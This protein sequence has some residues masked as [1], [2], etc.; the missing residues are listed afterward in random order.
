MA[1]SYAARLK[2]G[3][4][5]GVCGT[6]ELYDTPEEF[7]SKVEKLCNFLKES[8]Y[9]VVHTGAGISTAC[10]IPDFRGPNGVWTREL[11]AGKRP[12]SQEASLTSSECRF[13]DARPSLT[14][15]ALVLLVKLGL[16]Q[17]VV[18]QNVDGLHLRSGLPSECLAELHGN[19]FSE[20]CEACQRVC[21][22]NFEIGS[23]GLK[24]TGRRCRVCGGVL[25]DTLL[26]WDDPLP[27]D[28]LSLSREHS[29]R[30]ELALV[31]GSSLRVRPANA[32][33]L[34]T[35]GRFVICNLQRTPR[36]RR[37]TFVLR[38]QADRIM[39]V[40]LQRL[41]VPLL[42]I[43]RLCESLILQCS[44]LAPTVS[45]SAMKNSVKVDSS[46]SFGNTLHSCTSMESN[47]Q[48]DRLRWFLSI[49]SGD[50][51]INSLHF[52]SKI[53]L[54]VAE[55]ILAILEKPPFQCEFLLST[56]QFE[57]KALSSGSNGNDFSSQRKTLIELNLT[58]HLSPSCTEQTIAIQFPLD[59]SSLDL[60]SKIF[61]FP[62]VVV[63]HNVSLPVG[64]KQQL[65]EVNNETP[66]CRKR[67]HRNSSSL[68]RRRIL[69]K[70]VN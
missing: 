21:V 20:R 23:I 22:R 52:I 26:D 1:Q 13:E 12:N 66:P 9:T 38:A 35:R 29:R 70:K 65:S 47:V 57:A 48:C 56:S 64:E 40:L 33:P 37:A 27:E 24:P 16:V 34:E 53:V 15:M 5:Y 30:A 43:Y 2:K 28:T 4:Y 11:R 67:R 39:Y 6:P 59:S 60:Q 55:E 62:V 8:K 31:L 51:E 32:L 45:R 61:T 14:H 19:V 42:P 18:T 25:R 3:V 50:E 17:F 46:F 63:D 41:S 49:V 36:D 58:I 69:T 68:A 44:V 10:G 7:D 54:T